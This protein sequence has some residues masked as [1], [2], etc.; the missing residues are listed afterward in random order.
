MGRIALFALLGIVTAT[1]AASQSVGATL[2]ELLPTGS[3]RVEVLELWSPPRLGEL[4]RKLQ[5]AV[6][7]DPEWWQAHVRRAL[8]GQPMP[9]DA[10]LGLTEAEY[11][12]FLQLSD[13]VQMRPAR[14]DSLVLEAIP[15]G[16]RFAESTGLEILR[17]I[18]IDTVQG[19]V[20]SEFGDL[21]PSTPIEP[22]AAQKATGQWGGPQWRREEVDVAT[23]TGTVASF[24]VG[25]HATG[26][27]IIYFDGRQAEH[28][29]MTTRASVFL[30]LMRY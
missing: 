25:R 21:S 4:T 2:R 7:A 12:S 27:T 23:S 14:T 3:V 26:H 10:R 9:Y 17:G 24:A 15:S 11:R 13:S 22:S 6:R 5:R 1:P 28:G 20:R 30:R 18:E 16:W 8:P 29:Q 19:I